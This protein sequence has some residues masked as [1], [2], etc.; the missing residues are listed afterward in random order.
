MDS[1]PA[2]LLVL[3][4]SSPMTESFSIYVTVSL[5]LSSIKSSDTCN[6]LGAF[7]LLVRCSSQLDILFFPFSSLWLFYNNSSSSL[8]TRVCVA[9]PTTNL[10]HLFL[11]PPHN[12]SFI[13]SLLV[14]FSHP[15][16]IKGD[17]LVANQ[18]NNKNSAPSS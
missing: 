13:S 3:L 8:S 11:F 18:L 10:L 12:F 14:K 4:P 1:L 5:S 7:L 15:T 2:A 17:S 9:C 16:V 6:F